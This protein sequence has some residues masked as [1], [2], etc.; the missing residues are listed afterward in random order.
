MTPFVFDKSRGMLFKRGHKNMP[1]VKIE[2]LQLLPHKIS[3]DDGDY[4][5]F[6]LNLVLAGGERQHIASYSNRGNAARDAKI[7]ASQLMIKL[8]NK[9]NTNN[10]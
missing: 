2:A 3:D 7:L 6:Q 4:E 9:D 10:A 8:W 5:N 1:L